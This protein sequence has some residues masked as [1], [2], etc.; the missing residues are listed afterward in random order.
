MENR[1]YLDKKGIKHEDMTTGGGH[2]WMNARSYLTETLN[3]FFK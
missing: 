3:K 2:T 1:E